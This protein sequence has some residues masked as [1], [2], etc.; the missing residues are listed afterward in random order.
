MGLFSVQAIACALRPDNTLYPSD[1]LFPSADATSGYSGVYWNK[2]ADTYTRLGDG[3]QQSDFDGLYPWNQIVRVNLAD[4]GSLL[5]V[6]GDANFKYDGTNGQVMVRVPKFYYKVEQ[7]ADGYNWYISQNQLDGYKLY[8][9][10]I[11]D[12][13]TL[14]YFYIGAFEATAYD[15]SAGTYKTDDSAN[16]DFT[17]TTGDKLAS[18][19]GVKPL[20]GMNNS[21]SLPNARTIAKNRGMGWGLETYQQISALEMLYLIEYANFNSQSQI[22][23]G[24]TSITNDGTTNMAVNT[25]YTAGVG[26]GSTD[27]G[28]ASGYATITHYQTGQ[29]TYPISYRGVENLWGNIWKF[30]DGINIKTDFNS[31]IADHDFAS[32]TFTHPYSNTSFIQP[33]ANN[34]VSDIQ[35]SADYDYGFLASN[36]TGGSSTTK[37]CDYQY[38]DTGNRVVA[39]G[40]NWYLGAYDGAF[41]WYMGA[42]TITSYGRSIGARLSYNPAFVNINTTSA[43]VN[44]NIGSLSLN[45][46]LNDP[47][48]QPITVNYTLVNHTA[49]SDNDFTAQSGQLTYNV[50][51]NSKTITI[52][53]L[54]DNLYEPPED[55]YLN[56][57][58]QVNASLGVNESCIITIN[59]DDPTPT[60]TLSAS[61]TTV[62]ESN[63]N[64]VLTI[65][66]T[67]H[68]SLTSN[69][70]LST[71][72]GTASSP[73]DFISIN[74]NLSF[75]TN[76]YTKNVILS[77]ESNPEGWIKSYLDVGLFNA[78]GNATLGIPNTTKIYIYRNTTVNS[79]LL[80]QSIS[81]TMTHSQT[82][83]IN[84]TF[85]DPGL[86]WNDDLVYL[87]GMDD[88]GKFGY[89][90]FLLDEAVAHDGVVTYSFNVTAP[91]TPGA[92]KL[93][94]QLRYKSNYNFG[95]TAKQ[96]VA[97]T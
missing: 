78:T 49:H 15:V 40:G 14:D 71:V 12:N 4:N 3:S 37:L 69:V 46:T 92:Y 60:F 32:N 39:F 80:S 50:D 82:Y 38:F 21:L 55:F 24:V 30:V 45:V 6:Y 96:I 87:Y 97:V 95:A 28:N 72:N 36:V 52:A 54:D 51:E 88:A 94:Y 42:T 17:K 83:A 64:I 26:T 84:L 41:Y 79:T 66:K 56:L 5:A 47:A 31:W 91:A 9:A 18:I 61:Q 25:G 11:T 19:V 29:T 85:S 1:G 20:S 57:S 89:T 33:A 86:G 8:P 13:R 43:T 58:N 74:Q 22:K 90:K 93:E 70:T 27:L 44:E 65:T 76:E 53:I 16:V 68:T 75:S 63:T 77:I 59:D 34:Y 73:D 23:N 35:Y 10:F 62:Q 48:T 2:T 7:V 81:A 67:E